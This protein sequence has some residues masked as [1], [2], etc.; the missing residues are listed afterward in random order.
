MRALLLPFAFAAGLVA[1]LALPTTSEDSI[2]PETDLEDVSTA[3]A[4]ECV[5]YASFA[6]SIP[7]GKNK[8]AAETFLFA[9]VAPQ[10]GSM[11]SARKAYFCWVPSGPNGATPQLKEYDCYTNNAA[12]AMFSKGG[13][14]FSSAKNIPKSM[15]EQWADFKKEGLNFEPRS[16]GAITEA[17]YTTALQEFQCTAMVPAVYTTSTFKFPPAYPGI[18]ARR[19]FRETLPIRAKEMEEMYTCPG[20]DSVTVYGKF[21]YE[22]DFLEYAANA[23]MTKADKKAWI[24]SGITETPAESPTSLLG[25]QQGWKVMATEF[26]KLIKGKGCKMVNATA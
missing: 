2:V 4:P 10:I 17:E 22:T 6:Y 23:W 24:E 5:A 20:K 19:L 1:T 7:K 11:T 13:Y 16:G 21:K 9:D 25:P 8:G 14:H 3:S 18:E 15:N 12:A 26:P